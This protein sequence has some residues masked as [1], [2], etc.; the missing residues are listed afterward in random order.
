MTN[1]IFKTPVLKNKCYISHLTSPLKISLNEIKIKNIKKLNNSSGYYLNIYISQ[2]SN[3][4]VLEDINYIDKEALNS[5]ILNNDK[6]FNNGLEIEEL[7]ELYNLSYCPQSNAINC[8]LTSNIPY[9]I[10]IN[11]IEHCDEEKLLEILFNIRDLKKYI[12]SI[13][14]LHAGLYFYPEL[15][16]NKWVIKSINLTDIEYEKCEWDREEIENEW[17]NDVNEIIENINQDI[18]I[19]ENVINELTEYKNNINTLITEIKNLETTDIIWENKINSLKDIIKKSN[20][21][22]STNDNR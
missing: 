10:N 22:L 4:D 14:I 7:K 11:N 19:K 15:S 8:I 16:I 2:K 6:W 1:N 17:K 9:N 13:D 20:R 3:K 21:I 12:I 5:I 18:L